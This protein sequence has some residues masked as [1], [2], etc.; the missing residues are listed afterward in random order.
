MKAEV[1]VVAGSRHHRSIKS[2]SKPAS[3]PASQS[4]S[5]CHANA[6]NH[7]GRK[8]KS[9]FKSAYAFSYY[10]NLTISLAVVVP[11]FVDQVRSRIIQPIISW[12]R[13]VKR[14]ALHRIISQYV[15]II[16]ACVLQNMYFMGCLACAAFFDDCGFRCM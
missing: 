7:R 13:G 8:K 10:Y 9:I 16:T 14:G 6:L 3:L 11:V 4:A 1:V 15:I 2:A 5:P 12:A